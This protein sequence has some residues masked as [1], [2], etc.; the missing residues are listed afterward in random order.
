MQDVGKWKAL[1]V[2]NIGLYPA[3]LGQMQYL[4]E[5]L[6]RKFESNALP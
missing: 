4:R 2:E 1:Q 3:I 6:R 5:C